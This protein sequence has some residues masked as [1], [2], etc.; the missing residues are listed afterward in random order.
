[1]IF[2]FFDPEDCQKFM[3]RNRSRIEALQS[4]RYLW[5]LE[6]HWIKCPTCCWKHL[7]CTVWLVIMSDLRSVFEGV[8]R[9]IVLFV[10]FMGTISKAP[11]FH[12]HGV[13][14]I[15]RLL[16]NGPVS[17]WFLPVLRPWLAIL[18][19]IVITNVKESK[20]LTSWIMWGRQ[21]IDGIV[22]LL[23]SSP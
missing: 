22:F 7:L 3:Y 5:F 9:Y 20:R 4:Q 10:C 23:Y 6:G 21:Y 17:S 15:S 2:W 19:V 12:H 11:A 8:S 1:M 18:S 14:N 13:W 16:L